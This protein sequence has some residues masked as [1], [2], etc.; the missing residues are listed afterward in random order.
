MSYG[1]YLWHWPLVGLA[2]VLVPSIGVGGKVLWSAGALALAW[3][4]H[5]LVEEPLRTG[6]PSRVRMPVAGALC[7]VA[8]VVVALVAHGALRAAE[9]TVTQPAQQRFAAARVDRMTR[10]CWINTLEDVKDPCELGDVGAST[11]IALL[12]D[13]HAEHWLGG[14]DRAG[15]ERGWKID[16]MVKGGC[17]VAD[18]TGLMS[19]RVQSNFREC[20][21]YREAMLQR[22][23]AM[24]PAAVILSSWDHYVPVDGS[25]S[26]WQVTPE[27]WQRGLRRTY[28][29]LAAAGLAVIVLR[30]VPTIPF[31]AP[32]CLSRRAAGVPFT[33]PCTYDRAG[34]LSPVAVRAQD[35]AMKGLPIH[36]VDMNDQVCAARRC[37]VV[38]DGVIVF[39]DDNHLTATFSRSVGAVLGARLA[40]F[41]RR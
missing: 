12:G 39:T 20:S 38:R 14:L 37:G 30:D 40:P 32:G 2:A 4:T 41:V 8:S 35:A 29:R 15:K 18:M 27:T 7:F 19:S 23:I 9:R 17:P 16:A 21:R 24:R 13:S 5:R 31:D 22:I 36:L 34:A 28:Q 10:S 1:W 11:T 3:L 33:G 26:S 6:A 25:R